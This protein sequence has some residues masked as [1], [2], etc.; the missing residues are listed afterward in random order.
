[1]SQVRSKPQK[2]HPSNCDQNETQQTQTDF[3]THRPALAR[4]Q[5]RK[6]TSIRVFKNP[7][8]EALTHVNP[9]VPLLLWVPVITGLLV[10]TGQSPQNLKMT[11]AR[12]GALALGGLATWSLCEYWLHRLV[13]HFKARTPW[14]KR[15]Q[16]LIHGLHHA[17]PVD[18]T[19]LVMPPVA[20]LFWS[21]LFFL[22]FRALLGSEDCLP[23]FA[24]FLV[25]YLSYDYIHY[26]IHHFK[27]RT[28]W[29]R[30]LR[31]NH[32]LHHYANHGMRW[33]VSSPIWDWVF[34][35]LK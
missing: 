33:G 35:T 7:W 29:G 11:A 13:F 9:I 32:L 22:L 27:P 25:G 18:P 3:E 23:F 28:R 6:Q 20:G 26:S 31:R 14:Q 8:L 24:F 16:F 12:I 15:I 19:R 21:F 17:D 1:M 34:G 4:V 10:K 30:I 2:L 5:R